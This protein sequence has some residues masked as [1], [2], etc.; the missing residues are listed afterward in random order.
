M[1]QKRSMCN[2]TEE[3]MADA[4]ESRLLSRRPLTSIGRFSQV[5]R[6]VDC[7]RGRPDFV[8]ISSRR[9]ADKLGH[10]GRHS[11]ATARLLSLL[12]KRSPRSLESLVKCL[13]MT[14][15]VVQ[16]ALRQLISSGMVEEL[17]NGQFILSGGSAVFEIESTAFELKLK[18]P[19]R[20][21]FQAQQYTLFAQNVWIVVP[22]KQ[23]ASFEVYRPV[24]RRWGIGLATFNPLN[25]I[26]TPVITARRRSPGSREH[27]AYAMLR[28]VG[29]AVA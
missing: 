16:R 11:I 17:A 18:S 20:A 1:T 3:Q 24:L 7:H 5:F 19:R 26:F 10:H 21:V 23:A 14:R 2:Y 4:F 13:D 9:A 12:R 27:Q 28:L 22:P 8:G 6:E 25:H 29:T 15:S